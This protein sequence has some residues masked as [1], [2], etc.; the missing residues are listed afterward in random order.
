MV[1]AVLKY[2]VGHTVHTSQMQHVW[3]DE[4][5]VSLMITGGE[6]WGCDVIFIPCQTLN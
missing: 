3:W 6:M 2:I 1:K 5:S 4:I